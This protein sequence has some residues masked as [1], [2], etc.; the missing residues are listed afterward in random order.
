VGGIVA[1]DDDERVGT[2]IDSLVLQALPPGIRMD[3]IWVVAGGRRTRTVE[4]ARQRAASDPRIVVIDETER[5][6]KSAAL[7]E[8]FRRAEGDFVVLLNGDAVAE[9]GAVVAL[10]KA[11]PDTGGAFGVMGRPVPPPSDGSAIGRTMDL[12]WEVHHQLHDELAHRG[13]LTHLSDEI[14]LLPVHRLPP[15]PPGIVCDGSYAAGWI[16]GQG[17][18]LRYATSAR[19]QLTVPGRFRDHVAQRRRIRSG[20]HQGPEESA[21]ASSTIES[22][23]A[24]DPMAAVTVLL[25]SVRSV[26]QGF[27]TL[28]LLGGAEAVAAVL[29]RWDRWARVDRGLWP[30]IDSPPLDARDS[31]SHPA[32]G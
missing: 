19:V 32:Q 12:L 29:S 3:R 26:P 25:R 15:F 16:L 6:G 5:R 21:A 4:V 14:M 28:I 1:F 9:P 18:E 20:H 10:L 11:V 30:R 2:A 17:G 31:P 8:I 22:L 24:R 27:A 7:A 23:A 13:E